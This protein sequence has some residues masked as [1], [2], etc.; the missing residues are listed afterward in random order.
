VAAIAGLVKA[1]GVKVDVTGYADASGDPAQNA[2]I[3]KNRAKAVRDALQ[4]AGIDEASINM[5]PP[6]SFTGTGGD[7]EARRVDVAKAQ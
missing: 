6:A 7:A 4:A 3:A 1:D 2:E 5:K